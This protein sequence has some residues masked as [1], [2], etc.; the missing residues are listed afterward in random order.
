M[1]RCVQ[2]WPPSPSPVVMA[3][4][5]AKGAVSV[6]VLVQEALV[7]TASGYATFR[8]RSRNLCACLISFIRFKKPDSSL[9]PVNLKIGHFLAKTH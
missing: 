7:L 9:I 3:A 6:L 4:A 8:L 1:Q 5:E 2:S